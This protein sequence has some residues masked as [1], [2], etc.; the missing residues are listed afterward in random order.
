MIY[1]Y[2]CGNG[3]V[4]ERYLPVSEYRSAQTCNCGAMGKRK[5]S[6]PMLNLDMQPW[7]G[8]ISPATGKAITSHRERKRDMEES[9][10][11]DYE[12][13]LR[14]ENDRNV[15]KAEQELEKKIDSTVEK[16]ILEM[17]CD[18]RE[19]LGNEMASMECVIERR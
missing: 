15:V 4:F 1:E 12:P 2:V 16:A 9:G 19:R 13:S 8:Y 7:E 11:V 14:S 3:H 18:K 5:I 6:R 17:P 10:C